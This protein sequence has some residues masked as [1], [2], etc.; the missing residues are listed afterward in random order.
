V[1]VEYTIQNAGHFVLINNQSHLLVSFCV[2]GYLIIDPE[3]WDAELFLFVGR[4]ISLALFHGIQIDFP[5]APFYYKILSPD[6]L[7]DSADIDPELYY[8]STFLK[9]KR[10]N[11]VEELDLSFSV[12]IPGV[13]TIPNGRKKNVTDKNKSVYVQEY[14]IF[15]LIKPWNALSGLRMRDVFHQ[16][17]PALALN[18][19]TPSELFSLVNGAQKIDIE[20]W[21]DHS[22]LSNCRD[23]DL[24]DFFWK[25]IHGLDQ[26]GRSE[27]L[28]FVTG[29][30]RPPAMGFEFPQGDGVETIHCVDI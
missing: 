13:G 3:I 23:T 20:D 18:S 8:V 14:V 10:Q 16:L 24:Y 17:V 22:R 4:F 27:L 2:F 11:P 28:L 19:F 12:D 25:Y 21:H 15:T 6:H 1:P 9:K 30:S 5:L 29:S 26:E 7:S